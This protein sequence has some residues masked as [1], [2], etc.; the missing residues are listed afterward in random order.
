MCN[1]ARILK[2]GPKSGSPLWSIG[3]TK[4]AMVQR[5]QQSTSLQ[6]PKFK[7]CCSRICEATSIDKTGTKRQVAK[8]KLQLKGRKYVWHLS[9]GYLSSG[10]V[11]YSIALATNFLR[12]MKRPSPVQPT[13]DHSRKH[14]QI[15]R[16]NPLVNNI[17]K[18]NSSKWNPKPDG[19]KNLSVPR[20]AAV[21][22][23]GLTL[24]GRRV[25]YLGP[26]YWNK[27]CTKISMNPE[28]SE[29]GSSEPGIEYDTLYGLQQE[30]KTSRYL[31]RTQLE[32]GTSYKEQY[33]PKCQ[34]WNGNES[35]MT[36]S[37]AHTFVNQSEKP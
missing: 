33:L 16:K 29:V 9:A 24:N 2:N 31:N 17:R 20:R 6:I 1:C 7:T 23:F 18:E 4:P 37:K 36:W 26:Q 21:A 10:I 15:C 30:P 13:I 25:C 5:L 11:S 22:K 32:I 28:G 19:T 34:I 27:R 12:K 35:P 14:D 3:A 8:T